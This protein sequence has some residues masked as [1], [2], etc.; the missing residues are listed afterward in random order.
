MKKIYLLVLSLFLLSSPSWAQGNSESCG[1][2]SKYLYWTGEQNDDFFNEANW[3]IVNQR[4]S[5]PTPPGL[6]E[7]N[8]QGSVKP[9]CLPG[10]NKLPNQICP[11]EIDLSKDKIPAAGTIEPGMPIAYNLWIE[12]A[13]VEIPQSIS[14]VCSEIGLTLVNSELDVLATLDNGVVSLD[15]K[16]TLTVQQNGALET[17]VHVNFNDLESWVILKS[18][19][20]DAFLLT[21]QDRILV[22]DN[23]GTIDVDFRINQYYQSGT[24]IRPYSSTYDAL[25]IFS[26]TGLNG[27]SAVIH[28]ANIYSGSSIP[29]GMNDMTTSFKLK[30]GFMATFSV[31]ENGTSKSKV[32]I[33][34]TEDLIIAALPAALQGNVS[35][36]RVLP[37]N[38]VIKKGTG[39]FTEGV[40]AGW[41]Y[42]W[43]NGTDSQPNYE[44]VPMAWGAG[45]TAPPVLKR[46]IEKEKVNHLLGFNESDNCNDQSGQFNN[47]CKIEVAVGYYENL[48]K[49]GMRLGSPAPRENGPTGWLLEFAELAKERDV[50][51]DFVAVHW[52]DWGS[53]PANSPNADPQEIFNRFK[54]YLANVHRI[55]GLPIWITEFNANPNRGNAIQ[56]AF[57]ELALPYLESL[58]YVERYA[59]FE[60]NSAN[61][62]NPVDSADLTDEN[63]NLTNIGELYKNHLSTPSIPEATFESDGNLLGLNEPFIPETPEIISFEA[64]CA[65]YLGTKWE[66]IEDEESSNGKYLRGNN[67]LDGESPLASQLHFELDLTEA[68]T[69]KIWIRTKT[70]GGTGIKVKVDDGEFETVGGLNTSE[71][72]WLQLPRFYTLQAGKHRISFDYTNSSLLLD[73]LAFITT[74]DE[75]NLEPSPL[76]SCTESQERWGLTNTDI[77]YWLE[78]EAGTYGNLW[79][80]KTSTSAIGEEFIEAV[81]SGSS[82]NTPPGT[83]GQVSFNFEVDEKDQYRIWAKIQ[84]LSTEDNSLWIKVDDAPFR[85]WDNLEND[86]FEWYWKSF[87]FSEGGEDR[88]LSFFLSSGNHTLTIAY[89]TQDFKIDRL[90]VASEGK[91]PSEVDPDVVRVFGPMDYEA[92]N[93]ELLGN[94]IAVN[95]G[96]SS[97]GQQVNLRTGF[98]SGVRFNQVIA[99]EA[100]AYRLSV[101]YMSKVQRNFRLFVNGEALGYQLVTPSGNWCFE[102]GNTAI[103]EITVNLNQGVNVIEILRTETDAPFLDKISLNKKNISLEAE[104]ATLEGSSAIVNCPAA[105]NGAL[106]NMGFSY[107]NAI[108]FENVN[109]A[110]AGNYQLAITYLSAVDRTARVIINGTTE[111]VSFMDSGEWCGNGGTTATK[112]IEVELQAGANQIEIRPATNEAP[113]ID[114]IELIEIPKEQEGL[115][116]ARILSTE[117]IASLT[118]D[119]LLTMEDFNVYPNPARSFDRI[120]IILPNL[121][122]STT[123]NLSI[124]DMYGRV[125]ISETH[126]E[127]N[128]Q[129]IELQNNLRPGLYLILIQHGNQLIQH[130]LLVE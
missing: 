23:T 110:T 65:L 34:S 43:G 72:S 81:P 6:D 117:S 89:S 78:A 108:I 123:I 100:G 25:E 13:K 29:N 88:A 42:N 114:K 1:Q 86:A 118:S 68:K 45:A 62:S 46:I 39:G 119:V 112:T 35:F 69:F 91:L 76:N 31:A 14:F 21:M 5:A 40:D 59:Y 116:S 18:T 102:G 12:D 9:F 124:S 38:W 56:E 52:Y 129:R 73:Q 55:Y 125:W 64:E 79:E 85:K 16:S 111:Q 17:A 15:K 74:S 61:S 87:H 37:W 33:A 107:A 106:V 10:A 8:L 120:N 77:I 90:A 93:A 98:S 130:K 99:A 70:T 71:F 75:V 11:A 83:D 27:N 97:N 126:V 66:I 113:L 54:N 22:Q 57:L 122:E 4:P 105:S 84:S 80:V 50:R 101:H 47:L 7:G 60:P 115:A 63:G 24:L 30:R 92:E 36:I 82:L 103:Y 26:G 48:M 104:E 32:Y 2:L 51:F 109:V 53:G 20:P 95:C 41:Y 58:E 44:Y 49:T 127:A 121:Q 28:E 96:T 67:S 128:G 3:R 19:N 94:A